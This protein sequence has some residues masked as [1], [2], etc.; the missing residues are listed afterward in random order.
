[1]GKDRVSKILSKSGNSVKKSAKAHNLALVKYWL[2]FKK[3]CRKKKPE[4][5]K[6]PK[7]VNNLC[8][9]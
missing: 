1:M 2:G 4:A 9:G 8:T 5:H 6:P 3:S 7:G